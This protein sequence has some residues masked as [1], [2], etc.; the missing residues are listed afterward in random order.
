MSFLGNI[1]IGWI[2]L[3]QAS[4]SISGLALEDGRAETFLKRFK[5]WGGTPQKSLSSTW[6]GD[7]QFVIHFILFKAPNFKDNSNK[8]K[9]FYIMLLWE[10]RTITALIWKEFLPEQLALSV[11]IADDFGSWDLREHQIL[12]TYFPDEYTKVQ[13]R[14]VIWKRTG[15]CHRGLEKGS[16]AVWCSS[17]SF[18][19]SSTLIHSSFS[20]SFLLNIL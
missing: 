18:F 20:Y 17:F 14:G 5:G 1:I 10:A 16:W 9:P 13:K 19:L 12:L 7:M 11:N 3:T 15:I 2:L 4:R 6:F 8:K